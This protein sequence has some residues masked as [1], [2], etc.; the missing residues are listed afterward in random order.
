MR[1]G[2]SGEATSTLS[3]N[4]AEPSFFP[5]VAKPRARSMALIGA[6]TPP[7]RQPPNVR[8]PRP[9]LVQFVPSVDC[10]K[11]TR[12]TSGLA[13]PRAQARVEPSYD[14]AWFAELGLIS[15]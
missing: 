6:V 10:S 14:K 15:R 5:P 4:Q 3:R 8:V 12:Q 9:R 1:G 11:L 2:V 7:N 13:P